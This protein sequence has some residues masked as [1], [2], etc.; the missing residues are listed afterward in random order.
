MGSI[1]DVYVRSKLA[2]FYE[3]LISFFSIMGYID[4]ESTKI[5]KEYSMFSGRINHPSG[6]VRTPSPPVS[7]QAN[8]ELERL[9]TTL[10]G[11]KNISEVKATLETTYDR[12]KIIYKPEINSGRATKKTIMTQ[13][14]NKIVSSFPSIPR[15]F[16]EDHSTRFTSFKKDGPAI[17]NS[18]WEKMQNQR[19]VQYTPPAEPVATEAFVVQNSPPFIYAEAYPLTSMVIPDPIQ[20]IHSNN[21]KQFIEQLKSDLTYLYAASSADR[22]TYCKDF[23]ATHEIGTQDI[24]GDEYLRQFLETLRLECNQTYGSRGF[25]RPVTS[26]VKNDLRA[27]M[28]I[29]LD[30]MIEAEL[31]NKPLPVSPTYRPID[32]QTV[33]RAPTNIDPGYTKPSGAPNP[34]STHIPVSATVS[35]KE[36]KQ[37]QL[38]KLNTQIARM[39]M[40]QSILEFTTTEFEK[41]PARACYASGSIVPICIDALNTLYG[42]ALEKPPASPRHNNL[43]DDLSSHARFYEAQFRS[44]TPGTSYTMPSVDHPHE[45]QDAVRSHS[46]DSTLRYDI[47]CDG[48]SRCGKDKFGKEVNGYVAANVIS[49]EI[50]RR[51]QHNSELHK[52]LR[53]FAAICDNP[54]YSIEELERQSN[55]IKSTINQLLVNVTNEL[56]EQIGPSSTTF[57]LSFQVQSTAGNWHLITLSIGDSN[58]VVVTKDGTV[59]QLNPQMYD[60]NTDHAKDKRFSYDRL[61]RNPK[62]PA[63]MSEAGT[64]IS[65]DYMTSDAKNKLFISFVRLEKGDTVLNFSDGV[66]DGM[67]TM[68]SGGSRIT[69]Y[70]PFLAQ[71]VAL[72]RTLEL[73]DN[74]MA[75][76]VTLISFITSPKRDDISVTANT[77]N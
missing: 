70:E 71:T 15:Q 75:R 38:K 12:L 24:G 52:E 7:S 1:A 55:E 17:A 4:K 22:L 26:T 21:A 58:A 77:I 54:K 62:K 53:T 74:D 13:I 60:F 9:I 66:N 69:L 2:H 48:V 42:L 50:H 6:A 67:G 65:S 32:S 59:K 56:K 10:R 44:L 31:S 16:S 41:R 11:S 33:R 19:H 36:E 3:I 29:Y 73:A 37:L 20:T 72:G 39:E 28:A 76:L 27:T 30:R 25:D 63:K 40:K 45:N 68:D 46:V 61:S 49:D 14:L 5:G 34:T 8:I 18:L 64:T 43:G 57:Q 47:V 35:T 51:I 23:R